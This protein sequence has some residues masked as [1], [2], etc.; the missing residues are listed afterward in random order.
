MLVPVPA[1]VET[2]D[3]IS[4]VK[5]VADEGETR[6]LLWI[7]CMR[8]S[9]KPERMLVGHKEAMGYVI[10]ELTSQLRSITADAQLIPEVASF[11]NFID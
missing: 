6:Y 9:L 5:M 1:G 4:D 7:V 3:G 11:A 10:V 2:L 8:D